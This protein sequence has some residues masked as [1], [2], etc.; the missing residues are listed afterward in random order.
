MACNF[1]SG[2]SVRNSKQVIGQFMSPYGRITAR[3]GNRLSTA[4]A[5]SLATGTPPHP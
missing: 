3:Q 5:Y 1:S 4:R 2:R